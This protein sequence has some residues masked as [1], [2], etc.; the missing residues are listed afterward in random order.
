MGLTGDSQKRQLQTGFV[1]SLPPQLIA[2]DASKMKAFNNYKLTPGS[3][4]CCFM[5]ILSGFIAARTD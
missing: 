5:N 1:F 2:K 3:T 4:D